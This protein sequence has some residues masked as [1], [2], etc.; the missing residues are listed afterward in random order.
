MERR[1]STCPTDF[2]RASLLEFAGG[3]MYAF[4]GT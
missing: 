1:L 3:W 4:N 2:L